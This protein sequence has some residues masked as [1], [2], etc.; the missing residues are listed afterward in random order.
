MLGANICD[1]SDKFTPCGVQGYKSRSS[2][3]RG[4]MSLKATK[5]RLCHR[6]FVLCVVCVGQL[7]CVL[8]VKFGA[9][10]ILL[11]EILIVRTRASVAWRDS[12]AE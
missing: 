3:F 12:S 7:D 8:Y 2:L 6:V 9:C 4:Q 5:P 11:L 10:F 1:C